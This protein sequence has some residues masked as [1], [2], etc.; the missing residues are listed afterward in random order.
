MLSRIVASL[1]ALAVAEAIS[2]AGEGT[3]NATMVTLSLPRE[4][5]ASMLAPQL[6][7]GVPPSEVLRD[8]EHPVVFAFGFQQDVRPVIHVGKL[9]FDWTYQ[10]FILAVPFVR[11][12]DHP[13]RGQLTHPVNLYLDKLPPVVLGWAYGLPKM[14][15]DGFET[16]ASS[17]RVFAKPTNVSESQSVLSASW[18]GTGE[19]RAAAEFPNFAPLAEGLKLPL[20]G[21][22]HVPGVLCSN[23][24]WGLDVMQLTAATGNVGVDATFVGDIQQRQVPFVGLDESPVSGF[25]METKWTMSAP[26][27]CSK[28]NN[29][30][31]LV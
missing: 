27:E 29:Q 2:G 16:N 20:V 14:L 24:D 12:P 3:Y 1:A 28:L 18:R 22:S 5:V 23:F 8:G 17:Y 6:E 19:K 10:E 9:P 4:E 21:A 13:E 30:T 7:L 26:F 31:V 25:Q 15:A 11:F